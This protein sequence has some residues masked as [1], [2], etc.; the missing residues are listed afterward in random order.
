MLFGGPLEVGELP[1]APVHAETTAVQRSVPAP[2]LVR[3]IPGGTIRASS[4]TIR[5]ERKTS[6]GMKEDE[7]GLSSE[8]TIDSQVTSRSDSMNPEEKIEERVRRYCDAMRGDIVALCESI[9]GE[10]TTKDWRNKR[11]AVLLNLETILN[12]GL[13]ACWRPFSEALDWMDRNG[14]ADAETIKAKWKGISCGIKFEG[15]EKLAI[16]RK[17]L[18]GLGVAE[19]KESVCGGWFVEC[20]QQGNFEERLSKRNLGALERAW[21]LFAA[22]PSAGD[23]TVSDDER[24]NKLL[25]SQT[26]SS[27]AI[28]EPLLGSRRLIQFRTDFIEHCSMVNNSLE[29]VRE[30]KGERIKRLWK[31]VC[32]EWES[33]PTDRP[34]SPSV[35][36]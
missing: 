2:E 12:Q 9:A 8:S 26:A 15:R 1:S 30:E 5:R 24:V 3:L 10:N 14:D 4:S 32:M 11:V 22:E 25:K 36:S 34:P 33:E 17:K 21:A 19:E 13:A 23:S 16:V 20:P 18:V 31:M 7:G 27:L 28:F 6:E 29:A 35:V